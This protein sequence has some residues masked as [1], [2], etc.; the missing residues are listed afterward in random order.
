MR[1]AAPLALALSL[2]VAPPQAQAQFS[3]LGL[4]N[5]MVQF[6]L[7]RIS[8]PGELEI[9]ADG[10][11]RDEDGVTELVGV[12][13]ADGDGVW[14]EIDG[15]GLSWNARRILRGEIEIS[16]MAA[17]GV[18]V[19]RAPQ[20]AGVELAPPEQEA[21]PRSVF[22]WPRAPLTTRVEALRL[23]GVSIAAGVFTE[24]SLAFDAEGAL[25]D[26]GDEQS[27]RLTLR[28][29][30][31]VQGAI[32]LDYL[33]TFATPALRLKLT[34]DEGP[35]GVAAELAGFPAD[36]AARL[37]I[38]ADG[39]LDDWRM[40]FDA[41]AER[42]FTADGAATVVVGPPLSVDARVSVRPGPAM[43]P[44]IATVLGAE[45][46]L[47][48]RVSEDDAGLI[49]ID[50]GAIRSP[51]LTL[52][53]T[54]FFNRVSGALDLE[55]ALAA[56]AGLSAL[57]EGVEFRG[58]GFDGSVKGAV[59]D[60]T[61]TGALTLQGLETA[62]ADVGDARL[63]TT[64]TVR[65]AEIGF[66]VN[67]ALDGLRIDRVAADT[68][69]RTALNAR[70]LY[71]GAAVTL[72]TVRLASPLLTLEAAGRADIKADAAA[73]DYRL[74]TQDL[75]PLALAYDQDAAGAFEIAG[76]L[77]GA[78]SAPHIAG[79]ALLRDIAY[80]GETYG[81]LDLSHDVT[82]GAAP[83]GRVSLFSEGSRFGPAELATSFLFE[84]NRLS[85]DNLIAAALG[86]Q[87]S[88]AVAYD[89]DARLAEGAL[90]ARLADLGPLS[91][92]LDAPLTGAATL[93]LALR[94]EDA[95]QT[96][97]LTGQARD[98]SG[99]DARAGTLDIDVTARDALG[100]APRATATLRAADLAA[101]GATVA[102][103]RFEG[104]GEN[105]IAAPAAQG[106]LSVSGL[107]AMGASV[108]QA[109]LEGEGR[110][111][112]A[113]PAVEAVLT[114]R[115]LAYP[116]ADATV[117]ELRFEG[118]GE[119]LIAAPAARGVL[120]AS[121][122]AAAGATVGALRVEANGRDLLAAPQGALTALLE[123][124]AAGGAATPRVTLNAA[125]AQA[126][127]AA[128]LTADLNAAPATLPA[129]LPG[130]R[131]GAFTARAVVDDALG[132]A[133][134]IDATASVGPSEAGP[135][136]IAA[137]SAAARGPL[138]AIDA[139]LT[140]R[141][142]MRDGPA[143]A[144]D[145]AARIDAAAAA[146]S[147][148]I[149]AFTAAY[150]DAAA[151]LRAPLRIATGASTRFDGIDLSLP[152]GALTG[153][154]ALHP[155]GLSGDLTLAM[156]DLAP[157]ARL[158]D[159]PLDAGA[160]DAR[161]RFDTRPGNARAEISAQGRGLRPSGVDLG[162]DGFDIDA[163]ARWN[164]ARLS[165]TAEARGP[166][167][168]P[169][170]LE[171]A[172]PLRPTGGPLP[173]IPA[174]AG[175]EG[176][177]TWAGRLGDLWALVPAPDHV[178]D[179][180][181]AVDLTVSGR[182]AQP[183]VAGVVSMRDGRYE[184]LETG[185]IL[186]NLTIRSQAAPDGGFELDMDADDGA[187]APVSARA[188]LSGGALD[189]TLTATRAVL[190]RR[191][192]VTAEISADIRAQGP[193]A[194]PA[195][196]GTVTVDRAEARL[197]NALPPSVADLGEVRIKGAPPPPVA[198]PGAPIPLD[199]TISAPR[200]VFVRGRGLDSEW[201]IDMRV[202]G[203][204]A[205][206]VV[207]GVIERIRG[208][209]SLV[210]AVFAM[211][212]GAIRFTGATPVDPLLDIALLRETEGITGG[213]VVRGYAS[214][215][216]IAFESQPPLP[217]GEVLPRVLFGKSQQSLDAGEAIQLAAG[218]ATLFD[219]SGG[220]LDAVRATAGVDVLR[221][222]G[223]G[224]NASVTVGKNLADGVFVGARQPVDGGAASVIVEIE[225]FDNLIGDTEIGQEKGGSVGLSWRRNF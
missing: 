8:T 24:Q 160:L 185:T 106:V 222:E 157:L 179:G 196:S 220:A 79:T 149:S 5:S 49:R 87:V 161:A 111:L 180:D 192:D 44:E 32:A 41:E 128:R 154:A 127:G 175:V 206:P 62:P 61:A 200:N 90:D 168:Q 153:A 159:A 191:D 171:A 119:D 58:A 205:A 74:A 198:E 221:L 73:L 11:A 103:A 17:R 69:G 125:L 63:A 28:R 9:T 173:A 38:D 30:D 43:A 66:D 83:A 140:A 204:A 82:L 34:A 132:A 71:D 104:S 21:P 212:R 184:N 147:A 114:A 39:P 224:E 109:R 203:T 92:L 51:E 123:Q 214:T 193:L 130:A 7:S 155:D 93:K 31:A 89:L 67:G 15:V 81:R 25:R 142:A 182:L 166:F 121:G 112:L 169:L 158:A 95:T 145:A 141:G 85:L 163:D 94:P 14:L 64:V 70:G 35:G 143:L 209:L 219:G 136:T 218:L 102:E 150:G 210:G 225:I 50:E 126:E 122:V 207:S 165:A 133:P 100:A 56:G 12:K 202:G 46:R 60:L 84:N 135:A 55:V 181:V 223:A 96:V 52:D 110:D 16:R 26:E 146:P 75:R 194:S 76:R 98:L 2:L 4:Q 72:E 162:E 6:A 139:T 101:A 124:V 195:I 217:E 116:A 80:L 107:E 86:A 29:T 215:P 105:L 18:R 187:G 33:R 211:E 208:Q 10:V 53:A 91:Q 216:E 108:A 188:R 20:P 213:I 65:G 118:S 40:T 177:V 19:L 47:A 48:A 54:G 172:A 164:G 156:D 1:R 57:A 13:V 42:V 151:A 131:L 167:D 77:D 138:S 178:L 97:V 36:S 27:A 144:L 174:N 170:R 59:G 68:M 199:V 78:L 148:V 88:G 129:T 117:A 22:A 134:R 3:L 189:A 113:A 120:T 176:R 115:A 197:V 137:A 45:A 37:R 152:G 190:V 99:F 23:D 201:R 186:T 183:T